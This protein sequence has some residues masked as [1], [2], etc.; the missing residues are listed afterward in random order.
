MIADCL[1]ISTKGFYGLKKNGMIKKLQVLPKILHVQCIDI[2]IILTSIKF[3]L[4]RLDPKPDPRY[5]KIYRDQQRYED[6]S[7]IQETVHRNPN[8]LRYN[9]MR[10]KSDGERDR[11]RDSRE[12]QSGQ[13][14]MMD[15]R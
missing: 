11:G 6:Q 2:I 4:R 14:S 12:R 10:R 3:L 13:S 8:D 5:E 15:A 9:L 1:S 7:L